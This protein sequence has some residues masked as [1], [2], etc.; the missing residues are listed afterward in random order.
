[1]L[2]LGMPGRDGGDNYCFHSSSGVDHLYYLTWEVGWLGLV[3]HRAFTGV[4]EL[5]VMGVWKE[6]LLFVVLGYLT[7]QRRRYALHLA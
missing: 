3:K 7:T 2:G 6:D 5:W 4:M 1:M